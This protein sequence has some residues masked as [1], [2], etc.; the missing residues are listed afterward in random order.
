MIFL[1]PDCN[2][3]VSPSNDNNPQVSILHF[4][5]LTTIFESQFPIDNNLQV[6]ICVYDPLTII[7]KPQYD[8]NT[9]SQLSEVFP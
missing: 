1:S 9:I 6:S 7:F 4:A 2:L 5:L 8:F 3:Q